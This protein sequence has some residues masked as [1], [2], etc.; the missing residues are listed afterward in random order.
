MKP[1]FARPHRH[2][3]ITCF[4]LHVSPL[5]SGFVARDANR[6]HDLKLSS[7]HA[8]GYR[9]S[10]SEVLDWATREDLLLAEDYLTLDVVLSHFK[11]LLVESGQLKKGRF[12]RRFFGG[13]RFLLLVNTLQLSRRALSPV[14]NRATSSCEG[15]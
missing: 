14:L 3:Q 15:H 2:V 8:A 12:A 10:L 4:S 5:S 7:G 11:A 13:V 1:F 6:I 9:P